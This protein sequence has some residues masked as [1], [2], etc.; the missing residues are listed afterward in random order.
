MDQI[1]EG[2]GMTRKQLQEE[3]GIDSD[4]DVGADVDEDRVTKRKRALDAPASI[5]PKKRKR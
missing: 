1:T 5:D 3:A 2:S 4:T